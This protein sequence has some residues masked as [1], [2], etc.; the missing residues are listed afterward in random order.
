MRLLMATF[1]HETNTFSPVPTPVERFFKNRP[2]I[3][4]GEAALQEFEGTGSGLG[5]FINVERDH[6]AEITIALAAE[7]WPS[8][9]IPDAVY[10]ELTGYILDEVKKGGYDGI[11]LDLHGAMVAESFEDGEGELLRRI[12][13]I[14]ATTPVGVTLDMH[15]N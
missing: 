11:L 14:D 9:T 2:A 6:G 12:R 13:A 3:I 10:E 7:A 15:T 5:G 4:S 8:G 1:K